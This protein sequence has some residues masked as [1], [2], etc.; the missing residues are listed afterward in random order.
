MKESTTEYFHG[1]VVEVI[2]RTPSSLT[3]WT[4]ETP[5]RDRMLEEASVHHTGTCRRV[6]IW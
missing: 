3:Q 2:L 5:A 1:L 4:S 6:F